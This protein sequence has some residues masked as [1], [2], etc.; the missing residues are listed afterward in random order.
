MQILLSVAA[1]GALGAVSRW[2]ITSRLNI[3]TF[4][5]GTWIVNLLGS[6]LIGWLVIWVSGRDLSEAVRS[7]L[8]VGVLGGFTTFS[9]FSLEVVLLIERGDIRSA[10]V[11]VLASVTLCILM[12]FL[13]MW[14]ARQFY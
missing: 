3:A 14:L 8:I 2:L 4:P 12:A 10:G 5:W 7:G 1:G 13:G 6:F 9:A 11:Y